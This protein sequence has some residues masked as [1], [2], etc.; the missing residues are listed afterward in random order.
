MKKL[1]LLSLVLSSN[2]FTAQAPE[3]TAPTTI[4]AQRLPEQAS[5]VQNS[6]TQTPL[7]QASLVRAPLS[8]ASILQ[9][10]IVPYLESQDT[11]IQYQSSQEQLAEAQQELVTTQEQLV[12]TQDE[13]TQAE[14]EI[15]SL[16]DNC[17]SGDPACASELENTQELL[18]VTRESYLDALVDIENLNIDLTN[19][20]DELIETQASYLDALTDVGSLNDQLIETQASYLDALVDI[21]NLSDELIETQASYL[22]ALVDISNL[23]NELVVTQESYLDALSDITILSGE[24]IETQASYLDALVDISNLNNELVVTQESYLDALVDLDGADSQIDT[25]EL[26]LS[27]TAIPEASEI[28]TLLAS[29]FSLTPYAG[30][31]PNEPLVQRITDGLIPYLQASLAKLG[32][33]S[34]ITQIAAGFSHTVVLTANGR[35]YATGDNSSGQLGIGTSGNFTTTLTA[36]ASPGD[37]GVTAIAAGGSHTVVLKGDAA[38][39][40]GDNTS[41]QLGIGTSGDLRTTLTAM[42]SPGDTGVTA[43]A[44][45]QNF[46]IALKESGVAYGTGLNS[47]GQLGVGDTAPRTTLT[48]MASPG[49]TGVTAITAGAAH[50]VALKGGAAYATG[51]NSSGQLGVGVGDTTQRATLTAMASPGNTG[52]TAIAAGGQHTVVLKS[53]AGFSTGYNFFGQLGVTGFTSKTTLTPMTSPG[54]TGVTAIAAGNNHTV[55]LKGGAVYAAGNGSSGQLGF[56][57]TIEFRSFLTPML[58][59]GDTGVTAIAAGGSHTVALKGNAAYATGSNSLGQLGVE[60]PAPRTILTPAIWTLST[61]MNN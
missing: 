46:T 17:S 39:A 57:T 55:I 14:S 3:I 51:A 24:L 26:L 53:D 2:L 21:G 30:Q 5:V 31:N 45:G 19:L 16:I 58:S 28:D 38:Y 32:E 48:A 47:S 1:I 23:N 40:T 20:S 36:M 9:T 13:L 35:V 12:S 34:N 61:I 6:T 33:F 49:N 11:K 52:V 25:A 59:P 22:D 41:G 56:G 29:I 10:Q 4:K 42:L 7:E 27:G 18:L 44:A 15:Q 54:V 43:I 8:R 60:D 37:T 50:T